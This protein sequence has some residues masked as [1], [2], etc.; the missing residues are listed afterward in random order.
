MNLLLFD[1][2]LEYIAVAR[3]E[4]G[5]EIYSCFVAF[6]ICL[7][8][9]D[10]PAACN[11][12]SALLSCPDFIPDFLS[13]SPT[14]STVLTIARRRSRSDPCLLSLH[15]LLDHAKLRMSAGKMVVLQSRPNIFSCVAISF[16][17]R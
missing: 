1:R 17:G 8:K 14:Y 3:Q 16:C 6:K 5:G 4:G 7:T 10:V 9:K 2:A 11:E 15:E 12:L 13:V